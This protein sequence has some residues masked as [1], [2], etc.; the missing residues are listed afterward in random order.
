MEKTSYGLSDDDAINLQT[1][2]YKHT[3]SSILQVPWPVTLNLGTLGSFMLMMMTNI[4]KLVKKVKMQ[5]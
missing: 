2:K 5:L 3:F 4:Y 1:I